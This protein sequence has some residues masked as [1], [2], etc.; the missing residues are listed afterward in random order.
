MRCDECKWWKITGSSERKKETTDPDDLEGFCRRYPPV[1]NAASLIEDKDAF[2]G[3]SDSLY[4]CNPVT[5]AS[6]FC[7]EFNLRDSGSQDR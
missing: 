5:T 6:D 4:W 1:L 2:H 3:Q 7:G